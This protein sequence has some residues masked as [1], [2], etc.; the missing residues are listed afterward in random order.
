ME[1]WKQLFSGTVRYIDQRGKSARDDA[2][3]SFAYDD[4]LAI[5]VGNGTSPPTA[6]LWVH[7]KTIIL[8]IPDAKLPNVDAA[9]QWLEQHGYQAVVRNSGGL[10]VVLDAGVLNLSFILPDAKGIG[11][12]EGYQFMVAFIQDLFRN[13]TTEIKAFEI[14][15]SYCPGDYDL[16]IGGR[17]FAGISQRRVKNGSAV[18]IYLCVEGSGRERAELVRQF[19][20]IGMKGQ[21]NKFEY[22]EVKPE[23]MASLAEMLS[24]QL[25]VD[26]VC[27]WIY[28]ALKSVSTSITEQSLDNAE[29]QSFEKRLEQM[30]DRNIKALGI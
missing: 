29:Q 27:K 2:I 18:Q 11:I 13:L 7:D 21:S 8:G 9:I 25:T 22:P 5:S 19:Y 28:Q 24:I 23:T 4:A 6:R 30:K 17:K 14:K 10:A 20:G 16:S 1:D 12:H 15:G 3:A 26:D